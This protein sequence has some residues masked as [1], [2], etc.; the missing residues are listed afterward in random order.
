AA[1][2]ASRHAAVL[3]KRI[4]DLA[5]RAT[6]PKALT[7]LGPNGQSKQGAGT[8]RGAS[9]IL[10]T[11]LGPF[12]DD[13]AFEELPGALVADRLDA[14]WEAFGKLTVKLAQIDAAALA[15][16]IAELAARTTKPKALRALSRALA[17]L[18]D[19][20]RPDTA[21]AH[22]AA[23]GR[24]IVEVAATTRDLADLG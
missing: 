7:A 6:D 8:A 22:A 18:A 2:D 14:L 10:C 23:H 4:I 3:G 17:I 11:L 9:L 5:V 13:L 21:S 20:V 15:R 24:R 12:D 1:A 16:R 19:K